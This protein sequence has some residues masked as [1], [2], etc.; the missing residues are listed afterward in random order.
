MKS[1]IAHRGGAEDAEGR[2]LL[3][4]DPNSVSLWCDEILGYFT[5]EAQRTRRKEINNLCGL[6]VSVVSNSGFGE[7]VSLAKHVLSAV[8]GA[9]RR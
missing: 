9:R 3:R 2:I 7:E 1:R 6:R 4:H 8:E 5:A